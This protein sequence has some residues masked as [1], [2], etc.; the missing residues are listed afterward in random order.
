MRRSELASS[1]EHEQQNRPLEIG[2]HVCSRRSRPVLQRGSVAVEEAAGEIAIRS[3]PLMADFVA[4]IVD[5][6]EEE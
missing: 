2:S 3:G 5:G 6:P 1:S 4:K